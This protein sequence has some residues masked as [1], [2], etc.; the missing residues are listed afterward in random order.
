METQIV[1]DFS[2]QSPMTELDVAF[3]TRHLRGYSGIRRLSLKHFH[4]NLL[5]FTA[6]VPTEHI[7]I[8]RSNA[9][10]KKLE[11]IVGNAQ[12]RFYGWRTVDSKY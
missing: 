11:T 5:T 3:I 2:M 1:I 6:V 9:L 7:T 10:T 4:R 8:R 12:F